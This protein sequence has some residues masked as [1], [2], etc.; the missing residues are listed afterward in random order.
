MQFCFNIKSEAYFLNGTNTWNPKRYLLWA[1]HWMH[2]T[3]VNV[4]W[5][6]TFRQSTAWKHWTW[7]LYVYFWRLKEV[8]F[9]WW[10][11]SR[12]IKYPCCVS[13]LPAQ[14]T[15]T[16]ESRLVGQ[17][18]RGNRLKV[19]P[20]HSPFYHFLLMRRK[21]NGFISTGTNDISDLK[22][23]SHW[24]VTAE[25]WTV[26]IKH[27]TTAGTCF[28]PMFRQKWSNR[29]PSAFRTRLKAFLRN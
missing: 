2:S 16:G 26:A 9:M 12:A 6:D 4:K 24:Q 27:F 25:Q 10:V 1:L 18:A 13:Y 15:I 17:T 20:H 7:L 23:E 8:I 29:D 22:Q 5:V 3:S 21:R 11:G 14:G 28:F 19:L